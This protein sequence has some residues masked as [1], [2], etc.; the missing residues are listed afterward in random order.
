MNQTPHSTRQQHLLRWQNN[1]FPKF[2]RF[3]TEA[4][5]NRSTKGKVLLGVGV[6]L[7]IF[8]IWQAIL[9]IQAF[10]DFRVEFTNREKIFAQRA[11]WIDIANKY[12]GYRDAY[13]QIAVL[14]YQ[15]GDISTERKYLQKTI[16]AD[17]NFA[18]AQSLEKITETENT[19]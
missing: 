3:I 17:P 16:L 1:L 8:V 13:F 2:N 7:A 6:V 4:L 18:P 19:N 10:Q 9:L 12:P 5:K 11:L 14:S 15:I